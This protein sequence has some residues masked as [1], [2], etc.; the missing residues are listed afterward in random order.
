MP[1]IHILKRSPRHTRFLWRG[2]GLWLAAALLIVVSASWARA[3]VEAQTSRSAWK[4]IP[5][6][7]PTAGL[8]PPANIR[9]LNSLK[10]LQSQQPPPAGRYLLH[11]YFQPLHVTV[12]RE[13][14][15]FRNLSA[16]A[17]SLDGQKSLRPDYVGNSPL[18]P[19]HRIAL[20]VHISPTAVKPEFLLGFGQE[21][22]GRIQ[23]R[24]NGGT[25]LGTGPK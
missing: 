24:G 18:L 14:F 20:V 4:R 5:T 13:K 10:V 16:V 6:L 12:L 2:M 25:V 1:A 22:A 8:T 21:V 19:T 17:G 7:D 11:L 3:R 15:A 9:M 23:I